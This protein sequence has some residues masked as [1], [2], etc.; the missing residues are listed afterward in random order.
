MPAIPRQADY[1]TCCQFLQSSS[2]P[3]QVHVATQELAIVICDSKGLLVKSKARSLVF[4][5]EDGTKS[6]CGNAAGMDTQRKSL[7]DWCDDW[8]YSADLPVWNKHPKVIQDTGMRPDMEFHSSGTRKIIMVVLTIPY[9][10]RMEETNT[11]KI[12]KYKDLSKK[13]EKAAY[14]SRILSV[15]VGTRYFETSSYN[16]FSKL[17]I[18]G[19][20]RTEAPQVLA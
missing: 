3:G 18:N 5:L 20:R 11:Y 17:S 2:K 16:I 7:M 12:K 8:G 10:K 13:L 1:R 9:E 6:W 15:E 14:R 4:T 19:R